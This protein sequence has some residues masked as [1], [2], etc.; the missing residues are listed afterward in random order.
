MEDLR[1]KKIALIFGLSIEGAGATRNG[2]EMQHWCDKNGVDFKIFS[3]DESKFLRE[4]SHKISYTKFGSGD[5][6]DV[7]RELNTYD[8]VMF[9]TYPF[10]RVG[11]VAYENFYHKFVKK[12]TALKVGFMHE[13]N[14]V[15]ID[16]IPY[17]IGLMNE[18]DVIYTFGVDTWFSKNTSALLPSKKP[19]ERIKKFTMWFN[20]ELLEEYR[21]NVNLSDKEKKMLYLGRFVS[22]KDV[23][24]VLELGAKLIEKDPSF[25]TVIRGI[26]TSIGAKV[27]VL[28]HLNTINHLPKEPKVNANGCVPVYGPYV[29]DEGMNEMAHSLFGVSFWN[30]KKRG[31]EEYGDRMEYT[32]IETIAVG[33]IP[34]FD[35]HWGENNRTLEGTRYI[36]IPY[37]AIYC[38]REK[39]DETADELIKIAND[40]ELQEKYRNS[41]YNIAKQEFDADIVLPRMFSEMLAVGKDTDKFKSDDELLLSITNNPEFVEDAKKLVVNGDTVVYGYRELPNNILAVTDGSKQKEI[42]KYKK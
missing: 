23:P 3:Y 10:P 25:K 4:D 5:M 36:D 42:K 27:S 29:R 17:I 14:K 40:P 12:I 9:N 30:M 38:D 24:R 18:M 31:V 13:I 7:V 34:V 28:D 15:I 35:K 37:S 32:Q 21:K 6:D 33:T 39:L 1:G 2:S 26:D 20:F 16:K 19:N 8:I 41:S 11:Q 22:T